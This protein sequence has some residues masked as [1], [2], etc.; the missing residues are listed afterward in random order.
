[1]AALLAEY[2]NGC[3]PGRRPTMLAVLTMQ[4]RSPLR[5]SGSAARVTWNSPRTLT[6]NTRS[7]SSSDMLSRSRS[8]MAAVVPA[9]LTSASRRPNFSSTR[10]SMART[11]VSSLTS[12][13]TSKVPAPSFSA[14]AAALRAAAS[15]E[16]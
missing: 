9:L 2:G 11:L 6:A 13:F 14:S 15:L 10:F 12:H 16:L 8:F 5:S 7:H 4:G 1:M 3:G